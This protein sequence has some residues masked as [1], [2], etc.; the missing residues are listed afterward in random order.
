M[1]D[2]LTTQALSLKIGAL[3]EKYPPCVLKTVD[4]TNQEARRR[5]A[6]GS[7]AALIAAIGQTRGRGRLGRSF[8]SPDQTGVYFSI[9]YTPTGNARDAVAITSAAAVA[10]MRAI[11]SVCDVQTEI[12]WVN[13]LYLG[14]KKVAGILAESAMRLDNPS[15]RSLILGIGVNLTTETFPDEL[16][17]IAGSV[18]AKAERGDLRAGLIA[19]ILSELSPFLD[20]PTDRSWLDDYRRHSLV[21]GKRITYAQNNVTHTGIA[22]DVDQNGGLLVADDTNGLITLSTGEITVRI[23]N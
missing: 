8:Y 14:E 18:G 1:Q 12:K 17:A 20:D 21:L 23:Q 16:R 5:M 19:A 4:S 3:A 11:R 9:L 15:E 2:E 22:L 13:D 6:D 7:R 10:T